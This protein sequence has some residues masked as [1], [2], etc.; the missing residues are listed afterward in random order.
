MGTPKSDGEK[1]LQSCRVLGLYYSLTHQTERVM[2]AICGELEAGGHRVDLRRIKP[3]KEW[4]IPMGK[5]A[6]AY[7]WARMMAGVNVTQPLEPM[8]LNREDYDYIL[9][10]YQPW[11]LW[12]SIPVN[13]FLDSPMAE[14]FR[15]K[16]VIGV[17]TSRSRWEEAYQ[18]VRQ[19]VAR[20]G[21]RVVDTVIFQ[22]QLKYPENL[23]TTMYLIWE[24]HPPPEDHWVAQ[25]PPFGIGERA[26]D[27]ARD[28]GRDLSN[29]MAEDR[30]FDQA[31]W[32]LVNGYLP[33]VEPP[34]GASLRDRIRFRRKNV[35]LVKPK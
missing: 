24:G 4:T 20:R 14:V 16:K 30:V 11:N 33:D 28:Y 10:G 8:A 21:G 2:A 17:I 3:V 22:D 32:R 6:F 23:A 31:G 27:V 19:K 15:G 35:L 18:V 29:R 12:P 5:L 1:R 34:P 25:Y 13:A 9:L 26:Y 7:D